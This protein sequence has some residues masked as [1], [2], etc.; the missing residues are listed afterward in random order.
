MMARE[1]TYRCANCLD[2]TI[3]RSFDVSHISINCPEC[4]SFERFVN[5]TVIAKY[6]DLEAS[7]PDHMDW[8]ALSKLEKFYIS[9]K[10]VREGYDIEDFGTGE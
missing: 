1:R 8:D 10:L 5:E 4:D 2:A 9:D 3:T 6:D 7:P